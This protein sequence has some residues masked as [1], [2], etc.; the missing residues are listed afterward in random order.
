[1]RCG[2][3]VLVLPNVMLLLR[4]LS[5][6]SGMLRLSDNALS[7]VCPQFFL[8]QNDWSTRPAAGLAARSAAA[9][10]YERDEAP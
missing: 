2:P 5:M 6:M 1:M 10:D 7:N 9:W 4:C 3:L 8:R